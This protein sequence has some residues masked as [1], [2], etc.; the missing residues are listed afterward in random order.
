M[1]VE[2]KFMRSWSRNSVWES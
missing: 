1:C 2:G